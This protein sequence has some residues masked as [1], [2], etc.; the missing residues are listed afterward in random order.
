MFST[1]NDAQMMVVNGLSY[2]GTHIREGHALLEKP[3][4]LHKKTANFACAKLT[5]FLSFVMVRTQ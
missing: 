5:V 2:M 1:A 3:L 4:L